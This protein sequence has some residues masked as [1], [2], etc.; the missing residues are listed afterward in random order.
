MTRPLDF[1]GKTALISGAASGIGRA[2]AVQLAER[3]C[4]LA[5]VDIRA[6]E[7]AAT[8]AQLPQGHRVSTHVLD[9]ASR[10]AV[11]AL[12]AAVLTQHT[13]LDLLFNN[14]GV[15]VGGAFTETTE[16]DFD[17]LF[18]IN[19][20]SLVRVTRVFLPHLLERPEAHIVNTAS[21]FSLVAPAGQTH[22]A[23]SKFAVRGFSDA[24]RHELET[25]RVG[26]S[27]V[28]PGG[29]ATKIAS[30]ARFAARFSQTEIERRLAKANRMLRL[31]PEHAARAILRGVEQRKPR[32][33]VGNDAKIVSAFERLMPIGYWNLIRKLAS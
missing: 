33:V 27:V 15:A 12:P 11:A 10:E 22:Y 24:L 4:A 25:T 16:A 1:H 20:H 18:E 3:G 28:C 8:V 30:N 7:L 19:F 17:W 29:V 13:A 26:V 14:A 32:I 23:A 6:D 31:P 2:L 5:L 9:V 21:L